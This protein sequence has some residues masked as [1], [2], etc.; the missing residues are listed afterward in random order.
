MTLAIQRNKIVNNY[1]VQ[2]TMIKEEGHFKAAKLSKCENNSV[3]AELSRITDQ[4][5]RA[6]ASFEDKL[7]IAEEERERLIDEMR[8]K[9]RAQ[10]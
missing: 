2:S 3:S 1:H 6:A 5:S 7:R 4:S 9:R 10:V 8:N